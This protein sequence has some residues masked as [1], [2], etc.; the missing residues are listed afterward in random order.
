MSSAVNQSSR[1]AEIG[2]L[3]N[4]RPQYE[5]KG[6]KFV[7][8]PRSSDLPTFFSTYV[9]DAVATKPDHNVAIEVKSKPTQTSEQSIQWIRRIFE[10]HSDW[11]FTVAYIGSDALQAEHLPS[12][13]GELIS[14]RIGE[15]QDLAANGHLHAAFIIGWSLLEAALNSVRPNADKRPRTPGTVVQTLAMDG[16]ISEELERPL[17]SLISLRNRIVH[18][19]LGV[20]PKLKDLELVLAAVES[21]LSTSK[22][23]A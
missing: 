14:A 20:E 9:P 7:I 1:E 10:G 8:H 12:M 4:L 23:A 6:Y 15:V 11:Q 18:G 3:E 17:R 5:S 13:D 21:T 16:Y 2:F 19:D 22:K